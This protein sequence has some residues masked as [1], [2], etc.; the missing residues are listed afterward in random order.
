MEYFFAAC[1]LITTACSL[2][3]SHLLWKQ[4]HNTSSFNGG[5]TTIT[6]P[7]LGTIIQYPGNKP[8]CPNSI[9]STWDFS[10]ASKPETKPIG[11]IPGHLTTQNTTSW[12]WVKDPDNERRV[13]K[14]GSKFVVS[15]Q[16]FSEIVA[17]ES[18]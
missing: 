2:F 15:D 8:Y 5:L 1:S 3:L 14:Q 13:Y 16:T 17:R 10:P 18:K 7:D 6:T 4:K 9:V 11:I 12:S